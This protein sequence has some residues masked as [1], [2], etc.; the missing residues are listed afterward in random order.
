MILQT[1]CTIRFLIRHFSFSMINFA[2]E[3]VEEDIILQSDELNTQIDSHVVK[4]KKRSRKIKAAKKLHDVDE[5]SYFSCITS[6]YAVLIQTISIILVS[7]QEKY[8]HM[9]IRTIHLIENCSRIK[10]SL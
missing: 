5:G 1:V 7:H 10:F 4:R 9:G 3:V 2:P 6:K 8:G